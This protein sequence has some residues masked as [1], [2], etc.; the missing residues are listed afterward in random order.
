MCQQKYGCV[1][2]HGFYQQI[3]PEYA[4]FLKIYSNLLDGVEISRRGLVIGRGVSTNYKSLNK[5]KL[6]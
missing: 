4:I 5:I 3:K 2:Q 6:Y 1:N